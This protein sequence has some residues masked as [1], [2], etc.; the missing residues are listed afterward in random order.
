MQEKKL[1]LCSPPPN[2]FQVKSLKL[3]RDLGVVNDSNQ[4]ALCKVSFAIQSVIICFRI[5]LF[6]FYDRGSIIILP[7]LLNG[8]TNQPTVPRSPST[9]HLIFGVRG[10]CVGRLNLD[11]IFR[12]DENIPL[13]IDTL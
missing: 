8:P 3:M 2:F 7:I 13:L 4:M 9:S 11:C 10:V 5:P 6:I 12:F 1:M